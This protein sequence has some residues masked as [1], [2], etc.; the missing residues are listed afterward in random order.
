MPILSLLLVAVE[1]VVPV[2]EVLVVVAALL[3]FAA[4]EL[5][6][7]ISVLLHPSIRKAQARNDGRKSFLN[8]RCSCGS[9]LMLTELIFKGVEIAPR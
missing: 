2:V 8:I 5:L 7:F 6:L 4:A 9:A 1:E 3:V